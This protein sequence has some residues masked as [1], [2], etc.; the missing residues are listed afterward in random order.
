MKW[1]RGSS[2]L[3]AEVPEE[4]CGLIVHQQPAPPSQLNSKVSPGLEAVIAKALEKDRELRYQGAAE[5]RA[6]LQ[7]LKRDGDSRTAS[8]AARSSVELRFPH[9]RSP[10][11]L[12]GGFGL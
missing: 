9:S 12:W 4:I 11:A 5:L 10:R 7:R 1:R 3:T 2:R 8:T 6:D